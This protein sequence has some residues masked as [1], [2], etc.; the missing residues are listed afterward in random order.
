MLRT[1]PGRDGFGGSHGSKGVPLERPSLI[2]AMIGGGSNRYR[3]HVGGGVPT[4]EEMVEARNHAALLL[5]PGNG[6]DSGSSS[7]PRISYS[8]SESEKQRKRKVES[9]VAGVSLILIVSSLSLDRI[10]DEPAACTATVP[11]R[12][13]WSKP[14][15]S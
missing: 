14:G 8:G 15:V 2:G 10:Q 7:F 13:A 1:L 12:L 6:T 3:G 5:V 11:E 4:P 9:T